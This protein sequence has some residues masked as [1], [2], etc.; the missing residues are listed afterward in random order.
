MNTLN[1]TKAIKQLLALEHIYPN[2]IPDEI[3][4]ATGVFKYD[5]T[6]SNYIRR[7]QIHYQFLTAA[8]DKISAEEQ[9]ILIMERLRTLESFTVG[10]TNIQGLCINQFSPIY[11]GLDKEKHL[12]SF[13]LIAY[14]E[15]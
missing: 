11:V 5:S 9:S 7:G 10:N 3:A 14:C 2:T 1:F 15:Q 12:Y 8:A 4:L 13:N 6:G